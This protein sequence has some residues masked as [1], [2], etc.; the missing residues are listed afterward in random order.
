MA[1]AVPVRPRQKKR[2]RKR[3]TDSPIFDS[4]IVAR[5]GR[6]IDDRWPNLGRR[7]ASLVKTSR[8]KLDDFYSS[9][10]QVISEHQE[11][12]E[13]RLAERKAQA[14]AATRARQ[15]P[16]TSARPVRRGARGS[17]KGKT[18]KKSTGRLPSKK[19]ARSSEKPR[20]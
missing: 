20:S 10:A 6:Q 15:Q 18:V 9:I 7:L 17:V 19:P 14:R 8:E 1:S 3:K 4:K 16:G 11:A 5:F 2:A 12:F 13:D